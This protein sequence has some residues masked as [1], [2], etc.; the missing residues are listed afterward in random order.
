MIKIISQLSTKELCS[1]AAA[2]HTTVKFSISQ[3]RFTIKAMPS[4]GCVVHNAEN[5]RFHFKRFA[6]LEKVGATELSAYIKENGVL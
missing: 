4:G 3:E 5:K 1:L 6:D 2:R